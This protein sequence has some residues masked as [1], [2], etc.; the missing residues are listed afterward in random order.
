[1][2]FAESAVSIS[3]T[4]RFYSSTADN[5]QQHARGFCPECG[6]QLFAR[7]SAHP[8]LIGIKAGTLD[9]STRYQPQLDF[10]TQSA[11]AWDV[12]DPALPKKA[13]AAQ[14]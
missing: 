7:F 1:M 11:A 10:F 14:G 4:P 9:D 6:S 5:G 8:G 2:L 3:G 13:G 12:M